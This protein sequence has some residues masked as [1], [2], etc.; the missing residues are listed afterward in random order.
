[1]RYW[2]NLVEARRREPLPAKAAAPTEWEIE[3]AKF[4]AEDTAFAADLAKRSKYRNRFKE[5]ET[6]AEAD[7]FYPATAALSDA[8]TNAGE[9]A[10]VEYDSAE[11]WRIAF[12]SIS[13][14][15]PF[16]SDPEVQQWFKNH[17]YSW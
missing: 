15:E 14:T 16:N 13:L 9:T 6:A 11:Y 12:D 8:E 10:G 17:G 1:M 4:D 5:L 2:I 3:K 7:D